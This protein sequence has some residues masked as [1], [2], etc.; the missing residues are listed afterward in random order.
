M[1]FK[2]NKCGKEVAV[3]TFCYQCTCGGLWEL[4]FEPEFQMNKIDI[5]EWNLFRYRSFMPLE[6]NNWKDITL[7]EGLTDIVQDGNLYLK[8]DYLMPTLSFK[9]RGA[10][11][12]ISHCK[13]IGVEKVIQDSSGNAGNSIA[14]YAAKAGIECIIN[15]PE[16]TSPKKISMIKSHG[17]KV[18]II[19]G[20]RDHCAKITRE[21]AEKEGYYYASHVY[22]PYFYQGTKTYIYEVY[23]KLGKIPVNILIPVGNGTLYLGIIKGM[24]D[25]LRGGLID[26]MPKIYAVQSGNCAPLAKAKNSGSKMPEKI[27][28]IET[29]AE[30]IAIGFPARGEEILRLAEKYDIE[31]L[32]VEE[33][34]IDKAQ[35][36]LAEIGLYVEPT[37]AAVYG[38]YL[39]HESIFSN[40]EILLSLCGAGLKG[41]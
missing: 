11:V 24:E 30:G 13:S 9:N 4:P 33:S 41:K 16:G 15:V 14:A 36:K 10:A 22:N 25:L 32:T 1:N 21:I 6:D 28:P 27:I 37:T 19:S 31:F 38:A 7:G 3:N 18:N 29:K 26:E 8:M 17:A 12:L 20:S 35:K 39:E 40:E 34:S 23:E 2:C 5:R